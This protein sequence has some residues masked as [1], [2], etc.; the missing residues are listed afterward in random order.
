MVI[1]MEE[2]LLSIG[3][4]KFTFKRTSDRKGIAVCRYIYSYSD[5]QE[6]L[7]V[8]N[9]IPIDEFNKLL[10]YMNSLVEEE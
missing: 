7:E 9:I 2:E 6:K 10:K 4:N 5:S 3:V 1:F 8:L